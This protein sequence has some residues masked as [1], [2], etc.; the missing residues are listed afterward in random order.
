MTNSLLLIIV[1]PV[2]EKLPHLGAAYVLKTASEAGFKTGLADINMELFNKLKSFQKNWTVNIEYTEKEFFSKCFKKHNSLFQ[3]L[4]KKIKSEQY[5]HI[6]FTVL[7][8]NRNFCMETAK[9]I[10]KLFPEIKLIFG[11]PEVFAMGLEGF[12]GLDFIDHFVIGAGEAAVTEI[13]RNNSSQ[14][15]FEFVNPEKNGTFPDYKEFDLNLY[16]RRNA[17]PII[18]SRGCP[19]KCAFCSERLL[20]KNYQTREPET[21]I[22]EIKYHVN[23][24]NI[25]FFTF[26]DSIFNG[27]LKKLSAFL[28]LLIKSSI[29]I[30]WEA[31]IAVRNDMS[32][33]LLESMKKSGCVNLFVGLES[34]SGRILK[35]MR[36]PFTARDAGEFFFKLKKAGL[37]FEPSIIVNYPGETEEDFNK[38]MEFF[39][40]NSDNINKA[41]QINSYRKYPGTSSPE[42]VNPEVGEKK[43]KRLVKLLNDLNIR[44]TGKYINNLI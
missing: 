22:E 42:S 18:F 11:G 15:I 21:V 3:S 20:F 2:W 30:K 40:R 26:Y 7:N 13:L 33:E 41:A 34:G 31:Q 6:G 35:K 24:N 1:P 39:K 14:R 12:N 38:T 16:K 37:Q 9:F 10:K 43:I 25:S 28:R 23:Y 27:S 19:N 5:S 17:L 36:K 32:A 4:I 8:S 29:N 44:Y